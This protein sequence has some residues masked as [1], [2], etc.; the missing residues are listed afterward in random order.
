MLK[1]NS[2]KIKAGD[3]FIALKGPNYDGHDYVLEAIANGAKRVIVEH[4][5]YDVETV[6][7]KS[8]I[9]YLNNYL[10][11]LMPNI[12]VIGITGTNGKTT[13]SY[14]IYQALNKLGKKCAYIGTLGFYKPGTFQKLE[15]TTPDILKLYELLLK[16]KECEYVVMEVSS[17]GLAYGRVDTLTFDYAI[18]TNLTEDHLDYHKTMENYEK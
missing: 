3:T 8:T 14:I 2:K 11:V 9:N 5:K 7:V 16:C 1:S 10:K 6:I 4:G 13:T 17:Q 12:K 18:F 15:N